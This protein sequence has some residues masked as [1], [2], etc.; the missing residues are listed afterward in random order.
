MIPEDMLAEIESADFAAGLSIANDVAMFARIAARSHAVRSL[1][2]EL[3]V[4]A[5][6]KCLIER[7]KR[8]VSVEAAPDFR[9]P[10][11][12]PIAVYLF[13]L[14]KVDPADAEHGAATVEAAPSCCWAL[15]VVGA[16]IRGGTVPPLDP[17]IQ[18][19]Y[20]ELGLK[21][22]VPS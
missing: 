15:Q 19:A 1:A 6:R 21:D 14:S 11:D 20:E 16:C 7:I 3:E 10:H 9:H 5:K 17:A 12:V 4:P 2:W 8:L 13:L 22:R 18:R